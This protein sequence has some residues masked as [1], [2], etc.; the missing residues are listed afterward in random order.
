[1]MDLET[2]TFLDP[3]GSVLDETE[4]VAGAR[5]ISTMDVTPVHIRDGDRKAG[6]AGI[7]SNVVANSI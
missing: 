4:A 5:R 2:A 6:N 1:M 3:S 7:R